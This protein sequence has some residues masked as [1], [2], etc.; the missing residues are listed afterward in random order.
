[1]PSRSHVREA[2]L[3]RAGA[4]PSS[5]EVRRWD[6]CCSRRARTLG[7]STLSPAFQ[8]SSAHRRRA[9]LPAQR[10][11]HA[12]RQRSAAAPRS[13]W[14]SQEKIR[15]SAPWAYPPSPRLARWRASG[16]QI[17]Q[18]QPSLAT[19]GDCLRSCPA[20][21]RPPT[22]GTGPPCRPRVEAPAV[23]AGSRRSCTG[24]RART[25]NV[26]LH[27]AGIQAERV[28][29]ADSASRTRSYGAIAHHR[30]QQQDRQR[31][32]EQAVRDPLPTR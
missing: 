14:S 7:P 28:L 24:R 16:R 6:R 27:L 8:A 17:G 25:G 4:E 29:R 9:A 19:C 21:G 22:R 11:R 12:R 3:R 23:P 5:S 15:S 10:L 32:L 18:R 26:V 31:Q 30:E 2:Q 20:R 1:M 13:M